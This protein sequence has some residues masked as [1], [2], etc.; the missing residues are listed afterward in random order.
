MQQ[1][2]E[3]DEEDEIDEEEKE[4]IRKQSM[5]GLFMGFAMN[6]MKEAENQRLKRKNSENSYLTYGTEDISAINS[7]EKSKSVT[8]KP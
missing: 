7:P 6:D 1:D 8:P 2:E 3:S 4:A 5:A